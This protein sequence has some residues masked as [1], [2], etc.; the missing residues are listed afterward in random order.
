MVDDLFDMDSH[1]SGLFLFP[2]ALGTWGVTRS[3]TGDADQMMIGS[4]IDWHLAHHVVNLDKRPMD[5]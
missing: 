4:L 5:N 3:C 2:L 1:L